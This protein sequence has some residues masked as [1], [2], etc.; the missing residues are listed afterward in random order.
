MLALWTAMLLPGGALAAGQK[1]GGIYTIADDLIGGF[2]GSRRPGPRLQ[3]LFACLAGSLGQFSAMTASDGSTT[4]SEGGYF[5][6]HY[7]YERL[8]P[9]LPGEQFVPGAATGKAGTPS[10]LV[11]NVPYMIKVFATDSAFNVASTAAA[12]V[13]LTTSGFSTANQALNNGMTFFSNMVFTSSGI[14]RAVFASDLAGAVPAAQSSAVDVFDPTSSSPTITIS[15]GQNSIQTT[16]NGGIFGTAG[17][18]LGVTQVDVSIRRLSDGLYYDFSSGIVSA[19]QVDG[20]ATLDFPAQRLRPGTS[21][22]PIRT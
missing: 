16:L 11:T 20:S 9:I 18:A 5:S 4:S 3:L 22:W 13:Q 21:L 19:A 8:L 14:G 7:K 15:I 1:S 12:S 6:F 2:A 17:D 10:P